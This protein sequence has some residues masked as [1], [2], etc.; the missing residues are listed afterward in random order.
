MHPPTSRW[1]PLTALLLSLALLGAPRGAAARDAG[2]IAREAGL[3][4]AAATC[5]VGYAPLKV[6]IAASG[7]VVGGTAWLVT[8]GSRYPAYTIMERTAGGDWVITQAHLVGD[9]HFSMLGPPPRR[10]AY[11]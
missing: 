3:G 9:R 1:L 5:T 6:A 11:R 4:I 2:D 7:L 8:G 10:V